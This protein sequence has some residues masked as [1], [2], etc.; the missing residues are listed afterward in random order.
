MKFNEKL[1]S[2]PVGV[3]LFAALALAGLMGVFAFNAA[4][5]P[6]EAQATKMVSHPEN[7]DRAVATVRATD[8]GGKGL[9]WSIGGAD[10]E[11][12]TDQF[13]VSDRGVLTFKEPPNFENP[14]DAGP[15]NIYNVEVT[16]TD[17]NGET[18]KAQEFIITVTNVEEKGMVELT[19]LQPRVGVDLTANLSDEDVVDS[20]V[21]WQWAS[22]STMRGSYGNIANATN[23]TYTPVAGDVGRYLR[24]TASYKDRESATR[25]K[26]AYMPSHYPV[27][28][29]LGV[30]AANE[31]PS[32][33]QDPT[34][35]GVQML[36]DLDA[37][38]DGVQIEIPENSP[39]GANVGFPIAATDPDEGDR[40]TY[41]LA[42]TTSD[43][44]HSDYLAINRATGQIT[45]KKKLDFE[46]TDQCEDPNEC[47]VTVT[48]TDSS[49][50][51]ATPVTVDLVITVTDVNEPPKF[52]RGNKA[53]SLNEGISD[54]PSITIDADGDGTANTY[55]ATDPETPDTI[56]LT[57]SVSGTDGDYFALSTAGELT[58]VEDEAG[59]DYED[60]KD[61]NK[62][63]VYE[64]TLEVSDG[65]NTAMMDVKVT[66]KNMQ[67]TP[68]TVTFS[69]PQ[70]RQT[71]SFTAT[72]KDPDEGIREQ[73]WQWYD[74]DPDSD[75]D[76]DIDSNASPIAGA[77]SASYTPKA[78]DVGDTL[79][80]WVTYTDGKDSGQKATASSANTVQS[81][82][83]NRTPAFENALYERRVGEQ[84]AADGAVPG[85]PITADDPDN[86]PDADPPGVADA[87]V[88][89]YTV[90]GGD[91]IHFNVGNN[92]VLRIVDTLDFEKPEDSNRDNVYSFSLV[93]T[94][95]S[96][97]TDTTSVAVAVDDNDETLAVA[98][99]SRNVDE[100]VP[101]GT[102][103]GDPIE[104]TTMGDSTR[105]TYSLAD[106]TSGS[107]HSDYLAIN[108]ATG[109][110]T[111]KKKL[112][113]EAID[114]C[115]NPNECE[116]TVTVTDESG[117]DNAVTSAVTITVDDVNEAPEYPRTA[118]RYVAENT[119]ENKTLG[120]PV[121]SEGEGVNDAGSP[122]TSDDPVPATD[123]D[124]N[125]VLLYSLGGTD[126]MYFAIYRA[127][128]QVITK[129]LLDYEAL[130]E[131]DKTYQVT[132]TATDA[133]GLSDT[134]S[135]TIEVV[136]VH[137]A[138]E[139]ITGPNVSGPHSVN[140]AE[141]RTDAVGTYTYTTDGESEAMAAWTLEGDDAGDFSLSSSSG[142]STMLM[143]SPS[144]DFEMPADA[145]G[146]NVYMV[147]V[148]AM[149]GDDMGTR[150]VEV[151]VTDADEMGTVTVM[152]TM[153]RVGV[154]LT[155]TLDDPDR[156]QTITMWDWWTSDTMDGDYTMVPDELTSMYTPTA[157]DVGK[158]LKARVMYTDG[159]FGDGEEGSESMMVMMVS[160]SDATL[161]ALDLWLYPMTDPMTEIGDLTTTFMAD[162]M[163]YMVD[164]ENSVA[165]I[166]VNAVTN[167]DGATAA[168]TA[169]MGTDEVMVSSD[170]VLSLAVGDTEITV[171]VTAQDGTTMMTYMVTVT[172]AEM[173]D[174]EVTR[175]EV[176]ALIDAYLA[177]GAN[178]PTRAAVIALIDRYLSQ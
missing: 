175:A 66:V 8:P 37:D 32:F 154:E 76:G 120:N 158:Y 63:N 102:K 27:Q 147:T 14:T 108:R 134:V 26:S 52:T 151:T 55:A 116:V 69:H 40:L 173:V 94:D 142:M 169:M 135:L 18:S 89:K 96:G 70:P 121:V 45:V 54:T 51:P 88:L 34:E 111:V 161:S 163:S 56:T 39:V 71:V 170:N 22:S 28:E 178:A 29:K 83:P 153:A 127:S 53:V 171:T 166:K 48:V 160:S 3:A 67:E 114:Q 104:P 145:D 149:E 10:G 78:G 126:A 80:V 141:D 157:A 79:H 98:A 60:P 61:A 125:D 159:T 99:A 11:D 115:G 110:I 1:L 155:A 97:K 25:E 137:E 131:N 47:D 16:A 21:E 143:F 13:N 7:S 19:N 6:A 75:N 72:L 81:A 112:N 64:I 30:N 59:P 100:N 84:V 119:A 65:T 107:D 113:F 46:A 123:P 140:Y 139:I 103:V 57:W 4:A 20:V 164:A 9:N 90:T 174:Q 87:D 31:P 15:N 176:I 128:G 129:K 91:S 5:P 24:A 93:A 50:V 101:V 33:D 136:D 105:V 168:V 95:S 144:P 146:D 122:T 150:D 162:T 36:F 156:P 41:S 109:Q 44:D 118:T 42:D 68:G 167:H 85:D 23:P 38:E 82:G 2:L 49:G 177:G 148:K 17:S 92:G 12:G 165:Q 133:A 152:P 35:E 43:S 172:R 130:P 124:A 117:S 62:D 86:D 106:A 77:K 73:S 138:P 132:V 58:W 74:A